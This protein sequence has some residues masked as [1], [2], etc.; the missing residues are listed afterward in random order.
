MGPA[1]TRH[2]PTIA[3]RAS[4]LVKTF[5][6]QRALD[7]FDLM[8]PRGTVCGLLGPNGAG[9]TTAVRILCTLLRA[10]GGTA[11]VAGADVRADDEPSGTGSG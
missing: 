4:G 1:P 9:K 3:I 6:D 7:G 2:D 11:A 10:D 8:V 5:G